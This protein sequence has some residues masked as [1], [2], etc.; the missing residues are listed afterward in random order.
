[1]KTSNRESNPLRSRGWDG[2][3]RVAYAGICL[4]HHMTPRFCNGKD[5]TKLASS[6]LPLGQLEIVKA[7]LFDL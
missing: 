3:T 2:D 1:M 4:Q 7:A 6:P 5:G